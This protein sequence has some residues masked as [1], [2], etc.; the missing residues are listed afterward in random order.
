MSEGTQAQRKAPILISTEDVDDASHNSSLNDFN[1]PQM[2]S[3]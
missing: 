3:D 1:S 2:T